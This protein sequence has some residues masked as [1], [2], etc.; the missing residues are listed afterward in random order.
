MTEMFANAL[1]RKRFFIEMFT[2][3]ITLHDCILDLIDNS[4]D[5]A[6]RTR[7]IDLVDEI[8]SPDPV[9][10]L[11]RPPA[12]VTV[13]FSSR[14]VVV[15]DNCGGI[16]LDKAQ[17]EVFNF[18]HSLLGA[19]QLTQR[20]LGAY[21]IGMKRAIFK[22]G[23]HFQID[24]NTEASGFCIDQDLAQWS[25]NDSK[26]SDWRFPMNQTAAAASPAKAGTRIRLTDIQPDLRPL[27]DNADFAD[28]VRREVSRTYALFLKRHI[29]I[30]VND[31]SVEPSDIPLGSSQEY[32]L[33][34]ESWDD[35]GVH[36]HLVAGL[37][38]PAPD[39]SWRMEKAGWYVL[40]NGRV[41][42]SADKSELTGWG[43]GILPQF[44]SSKGRGF[45]GIA[46][47]Y[48]DD[49]LKLPWTTTKRGLNSESPVYLRAR[50]RMQSVARP[51]YSYLESLYKSQGEVTPEERSAAKEVTQADI[52]TTVRTPS[53]FAPPRRRRKTDKTGVQYSVNNSDLALVREHLR[54][55]GMSA[56]AI[57]QHT[58]DYFLEQEGLR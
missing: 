10:P 2:R 30:R 1:P 8:L 44:H 38:A 46:L 34:S 16:P 9:A 14:Q 20:G 53:T 45:V 36:V 13:A 54:S 50:N 3:D 4:V 26:L 27:L 56:S 52:L 18:G 24:S 28:L 12:K 11:E 55:P 35:D 22:I 58:F 42:V 19:G 21:G 47:F 25:E 49:P 37:A 17:K 51:V 23:N 7:N 40:C 39:G 6:I 32:N 48:S 31:L 29:K 5:S 33:S 43:A 57:G 41:T 15:E